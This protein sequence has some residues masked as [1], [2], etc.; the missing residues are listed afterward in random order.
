MTWNLFLIFTI[1]FK[2]LLFEI[3]IG[4][5]LPLNIKRP[6]KGLVEFS[7]SNDRIFNKYAICALFH[8][9][10]PSDFKLFFNQNKF[11]I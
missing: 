4:F 3:I 2:N 11:D 6:A 10:R 9:R 5:L 7:N 8:I 1:L